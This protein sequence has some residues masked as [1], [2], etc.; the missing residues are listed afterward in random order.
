MSNPL[1]RI[2][3]LIAKKKSVPVFEIQFGLYD[4]TSVEWNFFISDMLAVWG[5][6]F[7]E[8]F[9]LHNNECK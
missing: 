2:C 7:K 5:I 6:K 9:N 8:L 3:S 1:N 4:E